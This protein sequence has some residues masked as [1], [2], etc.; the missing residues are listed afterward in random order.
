MAV[1]EE[2]THSLRENRRVP[3]RIQPR[4]VHTVNVTS[5]FFIEGLRSLVKPGCA[6]GYQ[7]SNCK[8]DQI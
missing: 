1:Y 2:N 8:Y 4:I 7:M 3:S 6:I 5:I